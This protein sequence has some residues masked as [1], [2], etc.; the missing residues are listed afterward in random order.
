VI[1]ESDLSSA[2]M[3]PG[4]FQETLFTRGYTLPPSLFMRPMHPKTEIRPTS[5]AI[6]KILAAGWVGQL[7]IH[8]HRAQIHIPVDRK[9]EILVYNRQGRIH[10]KTIPASV[11][12]ELRRIFT[13]KEHWN[14]IDAEWIKAE[15]KVYVF[16][17]LKREGQALQRL[18]FMERWKQLPRAY[19]SP[20]I[21]T[22]GV[23]N[24]L[25]QCLK[26][27]ESKEKYREGLVFKSPSP[28]FQ[29]SSI[30]RCR[31]RFFPSL[32]L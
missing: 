3:T 7:K 27:L 23:L 20:S 15:D 29:D 2:S 17:F 18:N 26:A 11:Q 16:D 9:E 8:G 25:A 30:I 5:E 4:I 31:S 32:S 12:S 10:K 6:Q 13:P 28:G 14:V 22:L 21:K 1:K 19:L 24:T